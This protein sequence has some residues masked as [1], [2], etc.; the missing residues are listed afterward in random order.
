MKHQ[1]HLYGSDS[2]MFTAKVRGYMN[3]KG[4]DYELKK[5]GLYDL[6]V[7][8][9]KKIGA[10][11][12][13]ALKD[14]AGEWFGD[15]TEIIEEL[16]RRHPFRSIG[17]VS[18]RQMIAVMLFE[19]WVD[20]SWMV[21]SLHTRWSYQENIPGIRKEMANAMIPI[22]PQ[23]LKNAVISKALETRIRESMPKVGIIPE[24]I[25]TLEKWMVSLLDLLEAH[26]SKHAYLFGGRPTIADYS[27]FGPLFAHLNRDPW[28]KRE[29]MSSRPNLQTYSE[30]LFRGDDPVG[31]LPTDGSIPD[32]LDPI[33]RIIFSE[34]FPLVRKT[35][36]A[37]EE[38]VTNKG[39]Q[40]GDSLPRGV[41]K[42]TSPMG[43]STFTKGSVT[44]TL[45]MMQRIQTYYQ[46]LSETDKQDVANWFKEM[47]Q[48][49]LLEMNLGPKLERDGL[50]T[51]LA[52]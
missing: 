30:R 29:L 4:L 47:G 42:I 33:F 45:W 16:E 14:S 26:F 1:Y 43:D 6:A 9:P 49:D 8:L 51:R 41:D 21:I 22:G 38:L 31:D 28:P 19:A 15:S 52:K 40:P 35:V 36:T 27:L 5:I 20:E 24:Q 25:E 18:A 10:S 13:P 39:F 3:Y 34:F 48:S 37:V 32:T 11:A 17:T 44:Y 50:S 46:N 2:S 7:R 23:W 12:M